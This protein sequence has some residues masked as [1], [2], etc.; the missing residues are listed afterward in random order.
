MG[1]PKALL[2]FGPELMLQRV[3]RI[4][5]QVVD[6]IVV[7]AS[8]DQELPP[9]PDGVVVARDER[10]YLGPLAGVGIGLRALTGLA[11]AAYCSSCD[12]P[13]LRPEFV[14][15]VIAALGDSDAAVPREGDFYHPLAG[16]YSVALTERVA[17][18]VGTDRLRLLDLIEGCR[19][20]AIDAKQL[21][22]VDPELSSLRNVNS[23]DDYAA[24]LSDAGLTG[25]R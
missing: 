17:S 6:P 12:V 4:L 24:A 7:V 20:R 2:P 25:A 11:D 8:P 18:L 3:V 13:L 9:L 21:K 14:A 1:R 19:A 16:V 22:G 15:A 5:G 10:K 23:P